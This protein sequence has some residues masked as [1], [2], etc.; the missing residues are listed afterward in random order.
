MASNF[1]MKGISMNMR[2]LFRVCFG[3]LVSL[4]L[5]GVGQAAAKQPVS[6]AAS[7]EETAPFG[8]AIRVDRDG[9]RYL[10][11]SLVVTYSRDAGRGTARIASKR[12]QRI[13]EVEVESPL[14]QINA[15]VVSIDEDLSPAEEIDLIARVE[16]TPGVESVS[17]NYLRRIFGI[18][19]DPGY[20]KQWHLPQINA[21]AAWERNDA[22][23]AK[24]AVLDTGMDRNHPDLRN[25]TVSAE[26]TVGS[27]DGTMDPIG[28]GTHVAG[29][30]AAETNNGTGIAGVASG[31]TIA[32]YK[33][34]EVD[35]AGEGACPDAAIIKAIMNAVDTGAD[36]IN[37]SL[38][39][40]ARSPAEARAVSYALTR[41]TTLVAAAGNETTNKPQY[42]AAHRGVIAVSA[43]ARDGRFAHNYSNFGTWV[44]ISAPG[45][46]KDAS[47][48]ER[49]SENDVYSTLPT[50]DFRG[51][52]G[53]GWGGKHLPYGY[54]PGTS[55]AAPVVSGVAALLAARGYS[56]ERLRDRLLGTARNTDSSSHDP[57]Y[58]CGV[59]DADAA[60]D[61]DHEPRLCESVKPE[62]PRPVNW[63][64]VNARTGLRKAKKRLSTAKRRL[65]KARKQGAR[66]KVKRLKRQ[67]K[68]AKRSVRRQKQRVR[69]AC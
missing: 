10:E 44:D 24:I 30:A 17:R 22:V 39:G 18:P 63:A 36:V 1:T 5:F 28:H 59:V 49:F 66:R 31:A 38:G 57:L 56:G 29:I 50:T 15:G 14:S 55:M 19:N 69:R 40:S 4:L 52:E 32:V 20:S 37:M 67:V 13:P 46:S 21:P 35:A 12:L 2:M 33:V 68:R 23:G 47:P 64:C 42:P 48:D 41:G 62:P 11:G 34:C 7:A 16:A 3:L 65:R 53:W 43:T 8:G 61:P 26:N 25:V 6:G 51:S 60:T 45:G 27:T 9:N 54:A 58:G